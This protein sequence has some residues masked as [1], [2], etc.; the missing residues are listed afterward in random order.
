MGRT[1]SRK[2]PPRPERAKI[3]A[4][5]VREWRRSPSRPR[6]SPSKTGRVISE[7]DAAARLAAGRAGERHCASYLEEHGYEIIERNWVCPYGEIDLIC[8]RGAKIVFV[9]VKTRVDSPAARKYL[10]DTITAKKRR[11]LELLAGCYLRPRTRRMRP[12]EIRIDAV[13]VLLESDSLRLRE[14]IHLP[15]AVE[16]RW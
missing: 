9:E 10:F 4:E 6:F 16:V 5:L 1:T 3:V 14:I 8:R 2:K 15:A 7:A 12:E 11:K 13:G